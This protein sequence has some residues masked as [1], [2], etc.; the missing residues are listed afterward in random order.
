MS[1]LER[2]HVA[3]DSEEPLPDLNTGKRLLLCHGDGGVV[4]CGKIAACALDV[5]D[6]KAT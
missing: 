5:L 1:W 6:A 2:A 4:Q 3:E